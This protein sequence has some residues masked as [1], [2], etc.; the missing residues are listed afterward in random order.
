MKDYYD[1]LGVE[2]E[3]SQDDI[4]LLGT[5]VEGNETNPRAPEIGFDVSLGQGLDRH[6]VLGL[7]TIVSEHPK[8]AIDFDL[9]S[10]VRLGKLLE[11][12]VELGIGRFDPLRDP[13]VRFVV[14][15]LEHRL[16][17]FGTRD[18]LAQGRVLGLRR[19]V[20]RSQCL[21]G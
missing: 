3:A 15:L 8:Q 4:A 14:A 21:E 2:R 12:R 5:H 10:F 7:V 18:D 6:G 13:T 16:H 11:A 17:W 20:L 1:I 19:F 9:G